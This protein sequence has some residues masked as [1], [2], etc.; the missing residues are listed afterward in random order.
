MIDGV[1]TFEGMSCNG[2]PYKRDNGEWVPDEEARTR[3]LTWEAEDQRRKDELIWACRSRV[4]TDEE[5]QEIEHR[6]I[7]LFVRMN[8]GMSRPYQANEL[9]QRLNDLLLHQ[10][11]LRRI[12]ETGS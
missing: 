8:G 7:R 2:Y 1:A 11:K 6:G 4:C 12:N 5:M 3:Q 9:E 10:F